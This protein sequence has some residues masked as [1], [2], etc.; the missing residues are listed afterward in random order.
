[1]LLRIRKLRERWRNSKAHAVFTAC[2][3]V[4]PLSCAAAQLEVG[5]G[6]KLTM[7]YYQEGRWETNV[8]RVRVDISP[9]VWSAS[10][11]CAGSREEVH[12]DGKETL[13]IT[14]YPQND[15]GGP[16][17][18][19]MIKLFSGSRI[20]E[21]RPAEHLW[22]ALL[23]QTYFA[24]RSAAM[25]ADPGLCMNEP[26]LFTEIEFSKNDASPRR[27]R[28]QNERAVISSNQT[29]IEGSFTWGPVANLVVGSTV[30]PRSSQIS[31]KLV[32]PSGIVRPASFSEFEISEVGSV[33]S[34]ALVRPQLKGR[35]LVQ[36]YRVSD[37]GER[38]SVMYDIYDGK[39]PPVGSA[40]LRD[41]E[42]LSKSP[43]STKRSSSQ[44]IT[45]WIGFGLLSVALIITIR[46]HNKNQNQTTT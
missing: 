46:S 10:L 31:V 4:A 28:W 33:N 20:F 15:P 42:L 29:K 14:Q 43:V 18:T 13:W 24:N 38:R 7:A 27:L 8:W 34:N 5:V 11:E 44:R 41:V 45:I 23:S 19:S 17:N 32:H 1:M 40:R 12:S 25:G 16:L 6:G 2:F 22:L 26:S 39:L 3:I 36:D 35:S 37:A 21:S 30:I 9:P